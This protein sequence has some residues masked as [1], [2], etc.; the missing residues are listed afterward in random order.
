MIKNR[1]KR[2]HFRI[3]KKLAGTPERLRLCVKRSNKHIYAM[4]IDDTKNRVITAVSTLTKELREIK[5]PELKSETPLL[6]PEP[7]SGEGS[8]RKNLKSEKKGRP[9]IVLSNK[10]LKAKEVGMLLAKK[11]KEL[12]FKKVVFDRGGYKYHGRVKAIAEGVREAGLEC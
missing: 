11:A 7:Q 2:R 8:I 6:P 1:L 3:R 4:L 10:I 9:K 5:R 12:G